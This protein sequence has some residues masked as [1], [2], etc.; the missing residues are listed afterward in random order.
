MEVGLLL[1]GMDGAA[2][3]TASL[4]LG[5]AQCSAFVDHIMFEV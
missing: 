5:A 1:S 2:C 4:V 3:F